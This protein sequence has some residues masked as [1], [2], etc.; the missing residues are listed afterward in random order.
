MQS[1]SSVGPRNSSPA[2][3]SLVVF[4]LVCGLLAFVLWT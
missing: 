1:S 3:P 4:L 2:A